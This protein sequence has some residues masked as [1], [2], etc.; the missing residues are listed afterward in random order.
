MKIKD[1][2]LLLVL[3]FLMTGC[4]KLHPARSS[5]SSNITSIKGSISSI[6]SG[7]HPYIEILM[8]I[9]GTVSGGIY[10]PIL[11]FKKANFAVTENN[12]P[13]VLTD[14]TYSREPLSAV[15]VLDRSGSMI[16]DGSDIALNTAVI[17]FIE[18]LVG[19][20]AVEI[21]DFGDEVII[22]QKFTNDKDA[23]KDAINSSESFM[24][25]TAVWAAT[26]I[27]IQEIQKAPSVN[28]ILIVMT[29]GG[30][31]YSDVI[32]STTYPTVDAVIA[33]AQSVG[34]QVHTIGYT[35]SSI[36]GGRL[37]RLALETGGTYTFTPL[38]AD[39]IDIYKGFIPSV[40]DH[41][42]LHYRTLIK[43]S[44]SVEI[45]LNYGPFNEKYTSNYSS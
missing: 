13:V 28:K 35:Q 19:I 10:E 44:K 24:P 1:Y 45:F 40:I 22:K 8:K 17:S 14:I 20:D 26:G 6:A 30:D 36:S 4:R 12:G 42:V 16:W 31:N 41:A 23:L 43:G 38:A 3:L 39:L 2:L 25:A 21:I 29:D 27:G 33:F 5:P 15:L 11:D 18:G 9:E 34:Q 37:E 32:S 7:R